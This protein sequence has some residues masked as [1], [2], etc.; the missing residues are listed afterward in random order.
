M[1]ITV[2]SYVEVFFIEP[3]KNHFAVLD[4]SF[5]YQSLFYIKILPLKIIVVL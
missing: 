4:T 1:L 3:E 2:W 5:Y